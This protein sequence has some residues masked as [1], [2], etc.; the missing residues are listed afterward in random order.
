V[1]IN[2]ARLWFNLGF[3]YFQPAELLKI[4]LVVFL[5]AYLSEKRELLNAPFLLGGRVRLPPLP[6][7]LPALILWG[8]SLAI[9]VVEKDLGQGLLIFGIFLAMLYLASGRVSYVLVGLLAFA[10]GAYILYRI[11]PHVQTRVVIWLDPWSRGLGT[12]AQ[13]VQ[14]QY[15]L[16]TG[17]IFGTGLGLGDPT[18]IPLVQTD[19]V[20]S[21]IGEELGLLGTI[22]LLI[23]YAF[24]V[25]RGIR[26]ALDAVDD[27]SRYLAVGLMSVVG[28]QACIIIGG[29]I[30]LF[31]LTGIT[32]PFIS[33]GGSSL[34]SNFIIV[35]ILLAI[36]G[37]KPGRAV[38]IPGVL[39]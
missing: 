25:Y 31:P 19:F 15:A 13:L 3:F 24:F 36:S 22:A 37:M 35:G 23:F 17:G 2:G 10:V 7:L 8:L 26:I 11:F 9:V 12:G 6:Y 14:S 16:A 34:L 32:L 1:E 5:A 33:Y 21:A 30:G 4:I 38:A 39:A 28:L 27:F 29:T 18:N 20:F